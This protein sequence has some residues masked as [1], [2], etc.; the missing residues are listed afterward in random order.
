MIPDAKYERVR[1]DLLT[2]ILSGEFKSGKLPPLPKLAEECEV[3]LMTA[4]RAVKMLEKD[5][6][7]NCGPG[8]MG[9]SIN[10]SKARIYSADNRKNYIWTD[11]CMQYLDNVTLRYM[12]PDY[13]EATKVMW[14]QIAADF[15]SEYPW[16]KIEFV[17]DL[18]ENKESCEYDVFQVGGR[19]LKYHVRHR[20]VL[21]LNLFL[22]AHPETATYFTD[23][24]L[25]SGKVE[26]SLYG[27]PMLMNSPV[28]FYNKK[29]VKKAPADWS[30]FYAISK[31]L[32]TKG[33]FTAINIGMLSFFYHWTRNLQDEFSNS[34]DS[35][36]LESALQ[37]L[38]HLYISSP[39]LN[40]FGGTKKVISSFLEG[41]V[42]MFCSYTSPLKD[43]AA[44]PDFELGLAPLPTAYKP[45]KGLLTEVVLNSINPECK[46][47][48]DAWLFIKYLS[49]LSVQRLIAKYN[50]AIPVHKEFLQ[51]EFRHY[52]PELGNIVLDNLSELKFLSFSSRTMYSSYSRGYL[53]AE[54]YFHNEIS[55]KSALKQMREKM[56]EILLLDDLK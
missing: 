44:Y 14:D 48:S 38:K 33:K 20:N 55:I 49:S 10:L 41:D 4:R 15:S 54:K 46:H 16:I 22:Q 32:Q 28:I 19:D 7:V 53:V 34:G 6:I 9:T 45:K 36:I 50:Y 42:A 11:Q 3:S 31:S 43:I 51:N 52:S 29:F 12:A 24:L 39:E 18:S 23:I 5:E 1:K 27:L 40:G 8:S 25:N 2:R 37:L 21:D 56:N 47:P 26:S 13:Q 35:T 17:Q 30:E